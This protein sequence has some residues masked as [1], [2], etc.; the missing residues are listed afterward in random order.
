MG[1]IHGMPE[2]TFTKWRA[3]VSKNG[4]ISDRIEFL[5]SQIAYILAVHFGVKDAKFE[6][7]TVDGQRKYEKSEEINMKSKRRTFAGMDGRIVRHEH[8]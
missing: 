4:F 8:R 6:D 5:L 3:Y 1:Y 2:T 7:F